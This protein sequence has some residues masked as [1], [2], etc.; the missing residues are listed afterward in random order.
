MR[1]ILTKK[2]IKFIEAYGFAYNRTK[3]SHST[4][5]KKSHPKIITLMSNRKETGGHVLS[6]IIDI[7]GMKKDKFWEEISKF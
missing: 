2:L 1:Q 6:D 4:W 3:G 5:V 7:L